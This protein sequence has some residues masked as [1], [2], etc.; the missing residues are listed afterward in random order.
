MSPRLVKIPEASFLVSCS[1]LVEHDEKLDNLSVSLA[2]HSE[3]A[4][5][6]RSNYCYELSCSC[7]K[8]LLVHVQV[9]LNL[10]P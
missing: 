5:V 6:Q 10:I 9:M 3:M 1:S 8:S 4:Q 7:E 2:I